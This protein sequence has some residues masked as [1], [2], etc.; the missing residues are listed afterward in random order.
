MIG[1]LGGAVGQG[2]GSVMSGGS[3][4]QAGMGILGAAAP[5]LQQ[6]AGKF[7]SGI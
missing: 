7:L 3:I 6:M 5:A 2:L 4:G 1:G